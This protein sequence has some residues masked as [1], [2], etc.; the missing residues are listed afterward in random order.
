[1]YYQTAHGKPLI[2]GYLARALRRLVECYREDPGMGWLFTGSERPRPN[3]KAFLR[4]LED[5][6]I[7]DILMDPDDERGAELERF[8]LEEIY[9][10][11]WVVVRAVST[12]A[13]EY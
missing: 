8:G 4:S 11:P 6:E 5:L 10:D 12:S 9:R 2:G 7:T 1:M 3:R 13:N